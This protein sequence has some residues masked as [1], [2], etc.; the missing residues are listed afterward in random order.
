MIELGLITDATPA[1]LPAPLD[2]R[3]QV[4]LDDPEG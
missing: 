3:L 4:L 1:R 2:A